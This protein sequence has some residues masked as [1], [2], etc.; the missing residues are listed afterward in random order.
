MYASTALH[1]VGSSST[2]CT[3]WH[4]FKSKWEGFVNL[5]SKGHNLV[6]PQLLHPITIQSPPSHGRLSLQAASVTNCA[7][8]AS[9]GSWVLIPSVQFASCRTCPS[10]RVCCLWPWRTDSGLAGWGEESGWESAL[11]LLTQSKKWAIHFENLETKAAKQSKTVTHLQ[12]WEDSLHFWQNS[13]GSSPTEERQALRNRC[14]VTTMPP[15]TLSEFSLQQWSQL[16][17]H[18][19]LVSTSLWKPAQPGLEDSSPLAWW[20]KIPTALWVQQYRLWA[21][22]EQATTRLLR[23]NLTVSQIQE[24]PRSSQQWRDPGKEVMFVSFLLQGKEIPWSKAWV[25]GEVS[26]GDG[27]SASMKRGQT[28]TVQW[29][30]G[31]TKG[32][33]GPLLYPGTGMLAARLQV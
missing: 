19:S 7:T 33:V 14:S 15:N 30:A 21:R 10:N 22:L 5:N 24:F 12:P 29:Q 25:G 16:T 3:S 1:Q 31:S 23:T 18:R 32:R 26:T 27:G 17:E 4:V 20:P 6:N 28:L 8:W 2:V 9:P 11:G 13:K